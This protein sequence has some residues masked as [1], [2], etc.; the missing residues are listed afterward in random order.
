M[1]IIFNSITK[2]SKLQVGKHVVSANQ[3]HSKEPLF[4]LVVALSGILPLTKVWV[5]Y[6]PYPKNTF[7]IKVNDANVY[8]LTKEEVDY[9]P[10]KTET[11]NV[12]LNINNKKKSDG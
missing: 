9:N 6:L 12:Y 8:I 3:W 10:A 7:A 11:L 2:F 1:A 4:P 5:D